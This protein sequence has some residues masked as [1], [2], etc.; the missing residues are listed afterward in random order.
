ML[1]WQLLIP[2]M[3]EMEIAEIIR[4]GIEG[5]ILREVRYPGSAVNARFDGVAGALIE[6]LSEKISKKVVLSRSRV[7]KLSPIIDKTLGTG[8]MWLSNMSNLAL[9]STYQGGIFQ[10]MNN[11]P[12]ARR[13]M[14]V[15]QLDHRTCISCVSLHGTIHDVEEELFD[16]PNGRCMAM[17]LAGGPAVSLAAGEITVAKDMIVTPSMMSGVDWFVKQP[18]TTQ[19]AIMGPKAY[20]A[21][22]AGQID[23]PDLSR[24]HA[25]P[26]YG[27]IMTKDSV[28]N[29]LQK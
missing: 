13:W 23:I 28:K 29:A 14:W 10:T 8:M 4:Q 18:Q 26:L 24:S 16:H 1:S 5:E 15:A 21:W 22:K 3:S 9:W 7:P 19:I 11:Y 12:W 27:N 25:H 20:D 2:E 17:P 6:T